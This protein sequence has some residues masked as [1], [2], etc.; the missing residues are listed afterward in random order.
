MTHLL[1]TGVDVNAADSR[2]QSLL[3]RA[4]ADNTN[5]AVVAMLIDAGADVV[6]RDEEGNMPCHRAASNKNVE[7]MRQLISLSDINA[8]NDAGETPCICA[9]HEINY[10]VLELLIRAGANLH[11]V[12]NDDTTAMAVAVATED[13]KS[14]EIL[15]DANVDV[16]TVEADYGWTALHV[17]A[18]GCN[19]RL[20][21]KLIAAGADVNA[22]TVGGETPCHMLWRED[23]RQGLRMRCIRLRC[24]LQPRP[25]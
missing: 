21:A 12:D 23:A 20:I 4:A 22:R 17:A 14:V 11:A 25:M 5:A 13:E 3:H 16:N 18:A 24:S 7:V 6:A 2:G 1:A 19:H 15:V 8:V 9:T 10:D